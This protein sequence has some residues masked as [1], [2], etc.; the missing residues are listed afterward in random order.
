MEGSARVAINISIIAL[1]ATFFASL[2]FVVVYAFSKWWE[3]ES[4]RNMMSFEVA[5]TLVTGSSLS[6]LYFHDHVWY[7]WLRTAIFLPVP[8]ILVWRLWMLIRVQYLSSLDDSD[9]MSLS[10][11]PKHDQSDKA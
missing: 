10:Y 11:D 3:H 1:Y 6:R 4:G 9:E 5:I 2:A 8:I 7:T